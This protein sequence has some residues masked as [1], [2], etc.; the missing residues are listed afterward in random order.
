MDGVERWATP[1]KGHRTLYFTHTLNLEKQKMGKKWEKLKEARKKGLKK[2]IG[3]RQ[4]HLKERF[5]PSSG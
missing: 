2:P 1:R 3:A 5:S 4:R